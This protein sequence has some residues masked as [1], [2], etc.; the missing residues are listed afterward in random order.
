MMRKNSLQKEGICLP[1]SYTIEAAFLLP[2][3]LFA[4]MKGLLLGIDYYEDVCVA[5]ESLEVLESI[6][7]A[8]WIRKMQSAQKGVDLIHE[9]TI[10]EKPEK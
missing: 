5:A 2:L 1:G 4:M 7:P 3:F 9:Y 10:S 8:D 6:E